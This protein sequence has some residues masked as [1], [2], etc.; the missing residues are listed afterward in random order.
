[1][2]RST[3][4]LEE[5]VVAGFVVSLV[6]L[7]AALAVVFVARRVRRHELSTGD[8]GGARGALVVVAVASAAAVAALIVIVSSFFAVVPANT[9][10]VPVAFGSAGDPLP[11][12]IHVVTPWTETTEFSTRVQELSMLRATDEGD[13]DKDDSVDVIAKGGG[14][15]KVDLTIRFT[16]DPTRVDLVFR[17]AGSLQ[18]MKDRFV[19]PSARD[20]ARNVF[21]RYTAEQGYST[22]RAEIGAEITAELQKSLERHGI[23][24]EQV[25]VRDVLPEQQVLDS[26]NNILQT[27]ND[28]L[29]AQEDQIKQVTEAETRRQVAEKDAEAKKIAAQADADAQLIAAEAEAE[30]NRKVAESLTPELI[31][32]Q[33]AQACADAISNSNAQVISVCSPGQTGATGN[34][35][36][37]IIDGRTTAAG[38]G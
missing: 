35:P 28:A 26:I 37:V 19:R 11:S 6:V 16:I 12:G 34:A 31:E 23:L 30:S 15:M 13:L 14:A 5:S 18:V 25:N 21:G 27:R 10:A 33:K 3:R 4:M 8:V 32:L 1:M 2:S 24:V 29:Q 17:E 9:V 20:I 38:T 7:I 36:T 22:A